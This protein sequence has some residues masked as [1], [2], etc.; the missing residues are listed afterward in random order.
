[1][2]KKSDLTDAT[3]N[4]SSWS[5]AP[6]DSASTVQ[7]KAVKSENKAVVGATLTV[8]GDIT[9]TEDLLVEGRVEGAVTLR[10]NIVTIGK[11]GHVKGNIS[12]KTIHVVGSHT[13]NLYGDDQIIIHHGAHVVGDVAAPR[14]TLEDGAKLK[15]TIDM[16]SK[17]TQDSRPAA[18]RPNGATADS[19]FKAEKKSTVETNGELRGS[20]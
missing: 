6:S 4:S 12:A 13:G 20:V 10:S 7:T 17:A 8:T 3:E 1:M 5:A 16:D 11:S 9:G 18:N 14:V 2:W 15:G 19:S